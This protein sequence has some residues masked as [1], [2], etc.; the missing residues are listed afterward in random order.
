MK[1]TR[2]VQIR[3][4]EASK[5]RSAAER[6][7]RYIH[8]LRRRLRLQ[9]ERDRRRKWLLVLLLALLE[10]KPAQAFFP[11]VFAEPDPTHQKREPQPTNKSEKR[12]AAD[13]PR[14]DD[15]RRY[16]YD[17]APRRGEEHLEVYDGLTYADIIA[18][19]KI[20]R[21]WLFPKFEPI[22]GMPERYADGPVHIWTLLDHLGSDYHRP[23]A[24]TA[25]KLSVG[26]ESR[27]WIDACAAE[28]D[29]LTWKDLR[30][31]C[32]RRTPEMTIYEFP[33]AAARWRE[34]RRR[35]GEERKRELKE[36]PENGPKPV[37][38]D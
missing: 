28:V 32:R 29:G 16:L 5:R 9:D 30:R 12:I 25:L 11:V 23:E 24:I 6:F 26:V 27:D 35:E 31:Q 8:D 10:S 37:G 19:N 17:Y 38:P 3:K 13:N 20:H 2:A 15:E 18:N 14:T 34:E 1:P 36:T 4:K 21:P 33:R 7:R 22:P